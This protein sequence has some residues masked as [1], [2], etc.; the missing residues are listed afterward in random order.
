MQDAVGRDGAHLGHIDPEDRIHVFGQRDQE[1]VEGVG[2]MPALVGIGG[3]HDLPGPKGRAAR[4][5]DPR[6]LHVA[7]EGHR[8]VH[9][10]FVRD[11]D[12]ALA[13][14]ARV[15][16]G[17][18]ALEEGQLGAGRE[19]GVEGL[20]PDLPV[21]GRPFLVAEE[22][23]FARPFDAEGTDVTMIGHGEVQPF[24]E[25]RSTDRPVSIERRIAS[26]MRSVFNASP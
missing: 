7:H 2:R 16:V 17:V 23:G 21:A 3:G 13:V 25:S 1:I 6:H 10:G 14:P 15:Q 11:E 24:C 5:D 22:I 20:E 4:L 8:V 19:A 12:A 9:A 26:V 18:G